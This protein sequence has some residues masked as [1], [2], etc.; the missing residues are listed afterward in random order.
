MWCKFGLPRRSKKTVSEYRHFLTVSIEKGSSSGRRKVYA[1]GNF[2]EKVKYRIFQN[3]SPLYR[4]EFPTFKQVNFVN[5]YLWNRALG[6]RRRKGEKFNRPKTT[7][8]GKKKVH[9]F[10]NSIFS[11]LFRRLR[12]KSTK[13]INICLPF[14]SRR[15]C[16]SGMVR[17]M[18]LTAKKK[19]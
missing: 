15:N 10:N 13:F 3:Q 1:V 18:N 14:A 9:Y 2:F 12:R 4:G 6:E 5:R 8:L 19:K 7:L 16:V 11:N 17:R